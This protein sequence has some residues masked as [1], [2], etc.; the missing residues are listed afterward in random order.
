MR[1][2]DFDYLNSNISKPFNEKV[3]ARSEEMFKREILERAQLLYNLK[4]SSKDAIT[5][6][7]ENFSWEFDGTWTTK[8]PSIFEQI[9]ELVTSIYKK[10]EGKLD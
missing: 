7:K 5:R 10:L 4:Y 1:K 2:E 6:I 9:D 3:L 8:R